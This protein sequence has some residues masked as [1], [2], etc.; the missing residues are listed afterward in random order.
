MNQRLTGFLAFLRSQLPDP[1]AGVLEIGC[2]D[3]ELALALA[4]AGYR[5]T[6]V[7][8]R[9]PSGEIF[10]QVRFEELEAPDTFDAVVAS[11][12]LHHV[13][14]LG[15]ALERVAGLL[16]P[17]GQLILDEFAIERISGPTARWYFHQRQSLAAA[18]VTEAPPD[19]FEQWHAGWLEQRG[20]VHSSI[21]LRTEL[22]ARFEERLFAWRP[23][24]YSY[25][26]HDLL[27][28]LEQ[29]LIEEGAI[30]AT[31]YRYVGGRR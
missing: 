10:Q 9:A 8:P 25:R 7:D 16:A 5:V 30:D 18:G 29:R 2:G 31:G 19:D 3:G 22:D 28:P 14:D 12:S 20:D 1:P 15:T 21:A 26:L 23:Y 27:E 17:D 6:A 4:A 24:L 11:L 13:H